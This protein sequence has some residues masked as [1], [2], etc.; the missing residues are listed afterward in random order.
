MANYL[1]RTTKELLNSVSPNDLP[2]PEANYVVNPDL[3]AVTGEPNRYWKITGDVV[4][5]MD[6]GE[7]A[8]V[9][10]AI[11]SAETLDRR[12]DAE[13]EP[14]I[15]QDF[16]NVRVRALIELLNK[17]DNYLTNRIIELQNRVQA[18]LDSSG[19]VAN[20]RTAGLGVGISATTTRT[21]ADAITDYK[22]DINAGNQDT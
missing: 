18:M 3:S 6:A 19:N 9:D 8:A 4:T 7:Q 17:R 13:A 12:N 22:N 2:E 5:L 15:T 11:S 14:D 1:H 21:K 10:S 16:E 20:M